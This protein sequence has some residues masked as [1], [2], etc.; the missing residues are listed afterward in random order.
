[1]LLPDGHDPE[2]SSSSNRGADEVGSSCAGNSRYLVLGERKKAGDLNDAVTVT[3]AAQNRIGL[4]A[5][6]ITIE[7]SS[8]LRIL[9]LH[10]WHKDNEKSRV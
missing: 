1:L 7:L 9:S 10:N 4:E 6:Y 5:D 2:S 8:E 3:Q